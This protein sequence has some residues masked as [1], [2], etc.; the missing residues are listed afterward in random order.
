MTKEMMTKGVLQVL[1]PMGVLVTKG[2]LQ[3][4]CTVGVSVT[5]ETLRV[6]FGSYLQWES[7]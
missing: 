4:L 1:S 5:K 6:F 3:G 7:W 2:V